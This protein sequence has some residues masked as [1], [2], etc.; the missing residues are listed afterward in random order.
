MKQYAYL[1][2]AKYPYFKNALLT[3]VGLHLIIFS[4]AIVAPYIPFLKGKRGALQ[5]S[6][7]IR[8]DLVDL[9]D[10]LLPEMNKSMESTQDAIK[11]LK[12]ELK[13]TYVDP[14]AMKF[15]TKKQIAKLE[16][17][18]ASAVQR[19]KALQELEKNQQQSKREE[20]RKGNVKTEGANA[21]PS[22]QMGK[23]LDAY[24]SMILEKVKLR[25]A[26]PSYLRKIETLTGELIVFLDEDGSILRKQITSSGNP[27][28]DDFMNQA[29][30]ASL[31]F[32]SVPKEV[33]RDLRYDGISITFFAKELK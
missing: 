28:F 10:K 18:A 12:K 33:Q 21:P 27:E 31:P 17:E 23:A 25:W 15:K 22:E 2:Q 19:L 8:V 1:S 9:P 6:S 32:T 20:V 13:S 3:S 30:E 14:D 16:K 26:L 4:L 24:R 29:L 11:N 7:T 5:Y